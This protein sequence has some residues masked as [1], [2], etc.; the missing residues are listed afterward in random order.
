MRVSMINHKKQSW[1]RGQAEAGHVFVMHLVA[2]SELGHLITVPVSM[3]LLYSTPILLV[4]DI[5]TVHASL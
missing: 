4:L 3:Y 5:L 2:L 1:M